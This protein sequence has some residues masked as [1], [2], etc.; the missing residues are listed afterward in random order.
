MFEMKVHRFLSCADRG[1]S[2]A[3]RLT[4]TCHVCNMNMDRQ[5]GSLI[6]R[7]KRLPT[8]TWPGVQYSSRDIY[9]TV[10]IWTLQISTE[11]QY[12]RNFLVSVLHH[13]ISQEAGWQSMLA[14]NEWLVP[15]VRVWL[16]RRVSHAFTYQRLKV[17]RYH[18]TWFWVYGLCVVRNIKKG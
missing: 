14:V 17:L 3:R 13:I 9:V 10:E 16:D 11:C 5:V 7:T 8:S 1:A 12:T 15:Y 6:C 4:Y 18:S 2:D